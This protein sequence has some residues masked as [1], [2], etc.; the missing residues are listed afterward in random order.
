MVDGSG[1]SRLVHPEGRSGCV[2]L[3]SE[4][5]MDPSNRKL[6][7]GAR[8]GSLLGPQ[9]ILPGTP[10]KPVSTCVGLPVDGGGS[11]LQSLEIL[12]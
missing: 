2:K 4:L 5:W 1:L 9:G 10:V 11:R 7:K 6:R 3:R 12:I 8:S